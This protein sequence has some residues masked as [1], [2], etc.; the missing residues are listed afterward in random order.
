MSKILRI[1]IKS[2]DAFHGEILSAMREL[3]RKKKISSVK[4][5]PKEVVFFDSQV[6]FRKFFTAQKIEIL[7]IIKHVRPKSIYE[8]ATVAD[9]LFPAVL[10]DV[11]ALANY[12]FLKLEESGD[13]R[14]SLRPMLTFDYSY[15]VIEIP[16]RG[17]RVSL[18]AA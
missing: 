16:I 3:D 10:K 13:G 5:D 8:L 1:R 9:R 17:Y 11:K 6:S 15:I 12:G 14:K 2:A 4:S 7:A 18:Q